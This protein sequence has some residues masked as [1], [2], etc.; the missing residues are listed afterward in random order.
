MREFPKGLNRVVMYLRKSRADIEA[1]MRGEGETLSKHKKALL[2][3]AH[4]NEYNIIK[5]YEEIVSGERIADRPEVIRLL[6][7]VED[8]MYDAVLC[9]DIDRLGRGDMRDQGAII[10]AFKESKTL[11][12]TPQ[13]SYDLEDEFDEEYSEF[14]AFMARRELKLIN[15][16][17]Q[18]GR[19]ASVK[20]GRFIGTKAPY[21]YSKGDDLILVPNEKEAEI[22]RLIFRWYVNEKVGTSRISRRLNEMKIS[23]PSGKGL[24]SPYSV[25][26]ILRNEVYIGRMQWRKKYTN[27]KKGIEEWRPRDEWI[28]VE[29]KH[30]SL[31][32]TE[33]FKKA[34]QTLKQKTRVPNRANLKITNPLAGLVRCDLCSAAM[35]KRPYTKQAPHIRCSNVNCKNKSTRFEY[36]ERAV[37][38]QLQQWLNDFEVNMEEI[39]REVA[40]ETEAESISFTPETIISDMEKQLG[41]LEKQKNKLHDLLERGVYDIDTYLER[42]QNIMGR[43]SETKEAIKKVAEEASRVREQET[44]KENLLPRIKHVIEA[45]HQTEDPE[46]KNDLLKQVIEKVTYRKEK[47][48]RGDNFDLEIEIYL[49]E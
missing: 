45:Y 25:I 26:S 21:G 33:L 12:I 18:R 48:Q 2:E 41:E 14:E 15:K 34:Q 31:V 16:R 35:I 20:E 30:D 3:L 5:I 32:S 23:T 49:P 29:G 43:I 9:M 10:A 36:V 39:E 24:W 42:N 28:D 4:R 38:N 47:H 46:K 37:L 11:I 22:V 27:K 7:E 13:K 19:V 44:A 17:L 40:A 6:N 1:E 8:G